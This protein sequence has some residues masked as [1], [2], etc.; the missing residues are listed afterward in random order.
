MCQR[1]EGH[2][3]LENQGGESHFQPDRRAVV[4]GPGQGPKEDFGELSGKEGYAQADANPE[5]PRSFLSVLEDL[6]NENC[7]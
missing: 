1:L 2:Q 7:L 6:V 4:D 3:V 5:F